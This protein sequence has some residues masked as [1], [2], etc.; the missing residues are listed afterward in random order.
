MTI[1]RKQGE[2]VRRF[3]IDHLDKHPTDIAR[4]TADKFGISRQAVNRHLKRLIDEKAVLTAGE[5]RGRAYRLAPL[6]E[7][8]RTYR[9]REVSSEDAVW[10]EIA[11]VLGKLPQNVMRI[12][13]YGITEMVNNVM[14]HAGGTSVR[15][16][17][18][19]TAASIHISI[20]D[21]GVGIFRKITAAL[22]LLDERHAVLELAK[23]KLTTDPARHSGEGIF[24]TSRSFD[25]FRIVSG[26]VFF[27]HDFDDTDDLILERET[28][29]EGTMVEMELHNHT[30]RNLQSIFDQ[31]TTGDDFGFTKTIVPVRLAQY[32]D[33]HL[34]SRSQ[35]R[36][37]LARIDRFR[38][39][40]LDFTNVESIGQSFADE[41]FRVFQLQHPEVEL[42][43]TQANAEVKAM[44]S[45]ARTHLT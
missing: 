5:T 39:V 35:A 34:V 17:I 45:R 20:L 8:E 2:Q 12:W 18:R 26:G 7:W 30:A 21:D 10:R 37:L 38:T 42:V 3:I 6:E 13:Q 14:D 40:L 9:L 33:D 41:I 32:G 16:S 19:K 28:P 1:V 31:F 36:R 11:P 22:G 44:I 27:A 43:P 25:A 23:G 4:V 29:V 24:F 15:V